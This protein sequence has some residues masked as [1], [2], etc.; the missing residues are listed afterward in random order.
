MKKIV[1]LFLAMGMILSLLSITALAYGPFDQVP[2][3]LRISSYSAP[4]LNGDTQEHTEY[5]Y[6]RTEYIKRTDACSGEDSTA[7]FSAH[8]Y[9]VGSNQTG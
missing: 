1:S 9:F 5:S 3:Q 4:F 2:L 6:T 8:A 7:E